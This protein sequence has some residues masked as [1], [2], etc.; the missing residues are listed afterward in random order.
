[1]FIYFL[2]YPS[3]GRLMLMKDFGKVGD[4]CGRIGDFEGDLASEDG[5][6]G[7]GGG[8]K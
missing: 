5:A 4:S 7:V 8:I 1:M 2:T 6:R 3:V